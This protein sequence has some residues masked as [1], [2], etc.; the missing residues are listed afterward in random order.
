MLINQ[1]KGNSFPNRVCASQDM[2]LCLGLQ[3][4]IWISSCGSSI[5]Q[6]FLNCLLWSGIPSVHHTS[7]RSFREIRRSAVKFMRFPGACAYSPVHSLPRLLLIALQ[8]SSPP[9]CFLNHSVL[10]SKAV[11]FEILQGKEKSMIVAPAKFH[12]LHHLDTDGHESWILK[13]YINSSLLA[14]LWNR[15][16]VF[17]NV[18]TSLGVK[19]TYGPVI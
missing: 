1:N 13:P 15:G 6:S 16:H 14:I 19:A 10:E 3:Y 11:A 17:L 2:G 12:Q 7:W 5:A 9:C 8:G 18:K 4:Q